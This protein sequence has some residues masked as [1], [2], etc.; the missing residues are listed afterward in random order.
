MTEQVV[1]INRG[2]AI[3]SGG[4][5]EI[6]RLIDEHPH[7]VR[8]T[9]PRARD[10]A[11]RLAAEEHIAEMTFEGEDA[12]VVRTR[13]PETF[14]SQLPRIVVESAIP[15]HALESPDDNLEAVFRYLVD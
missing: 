4:I 15:I 2:K 10:L 5:R 7:T 9:T 12:L 8:L 1:L 6:R 13:D 3:A 11:Q 14:Y